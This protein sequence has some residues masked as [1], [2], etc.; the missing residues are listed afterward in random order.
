MMSVHKNQ[1][2]LGSESSPML[3]S[4]VD[5]TGLVYKLPRGLS[6]RWLAGQF[7]PHFE[8]FEKVRSEQFDF[9]RFKN[10]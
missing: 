8:N 6:D 1:I 5:S 10:N 3:I 7:K 2:E 9:W 4:A